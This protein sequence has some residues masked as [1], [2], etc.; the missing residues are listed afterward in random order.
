MAEYFFGSTGL[1]FTGSQVANR[2]RD[3]LADEFGLPTTFQG[4]ALIFPRIDNVILD[5]NYQ[6]GLDEWLYGLYFKC[7]APIVNTRWD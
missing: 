1:T 6:I 3:L 5:F 7:N 4:S 2:P